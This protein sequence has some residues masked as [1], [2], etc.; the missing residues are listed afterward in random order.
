MAREINMLKSHVGRDRVHPFLSASA[1]MLPSKQVQYII[2]AVFAAGVQQ[3][4]EAVQGA[5][6]AG[7]LTDRMIVAYT[8][9]QLV[10]L[11]EGLTAADER[12]E[13]WPASGATGG[14]SR[15]R[16]LQP[17]SNLPALDGGG[18][19]WRKTDGLHRC[20]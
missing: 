10:P 18:L 19:A 11:E 3:A 17:H 2:G 14:F 4:A 8:D 13:L 6:P 1:R 9:Q 7:T 5:A 16:D 20:T 12:H 15:N